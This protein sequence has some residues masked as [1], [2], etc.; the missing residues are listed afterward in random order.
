[1]AFA[2]KADPGEVYLNEQ[3][4]GFSGVYFKTVA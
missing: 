3:V 2:W 4:G 1:M